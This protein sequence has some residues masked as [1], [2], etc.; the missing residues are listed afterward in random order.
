MTVN[1]DTGPGLVI[2][3]GGL[4]ESR[5]YQRLA[6]TLA[7]VCTVYIPDVEGVD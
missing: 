4:R 7:D 5:H 3:H 2:M 6:S 1:T